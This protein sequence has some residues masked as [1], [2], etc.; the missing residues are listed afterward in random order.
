MNILFLDIETTGLNPYSNQILQVSARF[1]KDGDEIS[2]FNRMIAM[3]K[4]VSASAMVS[5]PM[6][7]SQVSLGALKVNRRSILNNLEGMSESGALEQFLD[8]IVELA[9]KY[10]KFVVCGHN[11]HFDINFLKQRSLYLGYSDF[12]DLFGHRY[13][14]TATIGLYLME[15]GVLP[16]EKAG[17]DNLVEYFG[18]NNEK[19]HDSEIDVEMTANIF[20]A[21]LEI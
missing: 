5:N 12:D 14:D 13:L 18:L 11:V 9:T 19:L 4:P 17:I 16:I 6:L 7:A 20:Y 10:D 2:S 3:S 21:M 8:W 1:D 15:K